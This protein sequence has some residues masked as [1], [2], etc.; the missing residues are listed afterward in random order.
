MASRRTMP[1][2][3]DAKSPELV[4]NLL[5]RARETTRRAAGRAVD[6]EAWRR[7]VGARIAERAKPGSLKQGV[8]SVEV[9]SSVWAQELSFLERELVSRLAAEGVTVSGLRFWVRPSARAAPI[10][11]ARARRPEPPPRPLPADLKA[12]LA[13]VDDPELRAAIAEAA[14]YWLARQERAALTSPTRRARAPR[15]DAKGSDRPDRAGS[16]SS[17]GS[18]RSSGGGRGSGR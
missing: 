17:A 15:S 6:A 18:R 2:A 16:P 13:A 5:E 8:L 4:G 9:A 7:A 14:G 3:A 1:R 10:E 11:S 12:R